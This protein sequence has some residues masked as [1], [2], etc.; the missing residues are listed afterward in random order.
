MQSR[1]RGGLADRFLQWE[2]VVIWMQFGGFAHQRRSGE[3]HERHLEP[4]PLPAVHSENFTVPS[5]PVP[6]PDQVPI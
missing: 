5:S 1:Y 2:V 4:E 3:V 6:V